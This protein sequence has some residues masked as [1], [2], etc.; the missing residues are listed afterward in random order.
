MIETRSAII[1]FEKPGI[2]YTIAKAVD[3]KI[4]DAI[5]NVEASKKLSGGKRAPLFIDIRKIKSQTRECQ[6]Y[7]SGVEGC[8]VFSAVAILVDSAFSRIM[9]N[10]FLG[11][12]RPIEPVPIRLFT[13]KDEAIIWL[14][15]LQMKDTIN[16]IK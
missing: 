10:F 8:K 4:D 9:A 14:K 15:K 12:R 6:M 7:Y 2:F 16:Q 11:L 5:E 1:T 13:D 3:Q